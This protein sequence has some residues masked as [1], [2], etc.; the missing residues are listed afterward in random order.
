MFEDRI[1]RLF[2]ANGYRDLLPPS[3]TTS[4]IRWP[5]NRGSAPDR[6]RRRLGAACHRLRPRRGSAGGHRHHPARA[7][8]QHRLL[9]SSVEMAERS[10]GQ[11]D[12]R[13]GTAILPAPDLWRTDRTSAPCTTCAAWPRCW[14]RSACLIGGR[15]RSRPPRRTR[16]ISEALALPA[17]KDMHRNGSLRRRC[18]PLG[19]Y[20][21]G[22]V[23]FGSHRRLGSRYRQKS[24]VI[25]P[26]KRVSPHGQ[27]HVAI[28]PAGSVPSTS[29]GIMKPYFLPKVTFNSWPMPLTTL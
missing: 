7:D 28:H 9:R 15:N 11:R 27:P 8:A 4:P 12:R 13:H 20:P 25:P 10:A 23:P 21:G 17:T 16:K 29:G 22:Q 3:N 5:A 19:D 24:G 14:S 1:E 18:A 6:D 2:E 26:L